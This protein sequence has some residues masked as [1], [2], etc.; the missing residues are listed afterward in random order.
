MFIRIL[1]AL[2]AALLLAQS[3][4]LYGLASANGI[5]Y[6]LGIAFVVLL[7]V[8]RRAAF[9][10]VGSFFVATLLIWGT[11]GGLGLL[12]KQGNS[13]DRILAA[14]D[15]VLDTRMYKPGVDIAMTQAS[16]DLGVMTTDALVPRMPREIEFRTDNLGFRNRSPLQ[17]DDTVLVG[18][19]FVQ[20]SGN[21][22]SDTLAAV[23]G[24]EFGIAAYSLGAPGDLYAYVTRIQAFAKDHKGPVYLFLF[25]GEDFGHYGKTLRPVLHRYVRL[26][27]T[28]DMAKFCNMQLET[29]RAGETSSAVSTLRLE[30]IRLA[31][32]QANINET[33]KPQCAAGE[34][35]TLLIASLKDSV[36]GIFFIPTKYRVYAPLLETADA[37]TLPSA[38]WDFLKAASDEAKIPCYNL[39]EPL[40]AE[41]RNTWEKSRE[42]LW[43]PDDSHWNRNGATVAAQAIAALQ[44]PEV[45]GQPLN[46]VQNNGQNDVQNATQNAP[47]NTMTTPPKQIEQAQKAAAGAQKPEE[48]KAAQ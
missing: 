39:T 24:K 6:L 45:F 14:Y 8:P 22:Q 34:V 21:T 9:S 7:F 47:Q 19:A 16:G 26:M 27:D 10:A 48:A 30:N 4:A 40:Q 5:A 15:M 23:L 17:P 36:D 11:V 31:F 3:V 32:S 43:W 20:G 33:Q 12:G 28:T 1:M 46:N 13:P 42:L 44:K 35:F 29:L 38:D 18:G 2:V 37:A 41:A 25:E